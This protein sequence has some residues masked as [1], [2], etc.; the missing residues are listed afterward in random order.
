MEQVIKQFSHIIKSYQVLEDF[1]SAKKVIFKA[2]IEFINLSKLFARDILIR[3][4]ESEIKVP[5]GWLIEK[6]GFKGKRFNNYGIHKN[7]ALV[8]VNYGG[9]KGEDIYKLALLIKST[10]KRLFNIDIEPE[11]NVI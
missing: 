9:A 6:A 4:S 2:K 5:A 10:I 1:I 8:L 3:I 11:V 7:Q